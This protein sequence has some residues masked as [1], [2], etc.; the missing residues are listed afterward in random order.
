MTNKELLERFCLKGYTKRAAKIIL[1]DFVEVVQE[2][3]V[4]GENIF[5]SGLGRFEVH[6][7]APKSMVDVYTG[8][9]RITPAHN[10]PKFT[11]SQK[12]RRICKQGYID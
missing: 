6:H 8:E 7:H 10:V 9:R 11:A 5:L 3:L 2:A 4:E 1:H 12:L